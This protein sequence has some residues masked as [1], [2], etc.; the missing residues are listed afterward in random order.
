MGKAIID[1]DTLT[2]IADAIKTKK[3]TSDSIPTTNMRS[4]ILS[5]SGGGEISHREV[6][7]I[8]C[9]GA[10][11]IKTGIY[12]TPL[13]SIEM[14]CRLTSNIEGE[15]FLFGT[16]YG[17][18]YSVWQACFD[19]EVSGDFLIS[20]SPDYDEYRVFYRGDLTK[21]DFLDYVIVKL[22]VAN[23]YINNELV[24]T[25]S[26]TASDEYCHYPFQLYIFSINDTEETKANPIN[27]SSHLECKYVKIWDANDNLILDLIP[28][29][30]SDGT[31]CMYDKVTER[32]YYNAG[33]GAFSYSE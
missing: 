9:D 8:I 21:E 2:G 12:P 5:I 17:G 23:V 26:G 19:K 22:S 1:E 28:V 4:E 14:E 6:A 20:R 15:N 32:Y 29:V 16:R 11:Y 24:G 27:V 7:S 31:V 18:S 25:V 10:S 3:G 13:Y 30:K 33:T